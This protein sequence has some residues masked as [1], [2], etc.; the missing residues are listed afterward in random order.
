MDWG[1]VLR[2]AVTALKTLP[3]Q[4]LQD[5]QP[6][7]QRLKQTIISASSSAVER[8]SPFI[9]ISESRNPS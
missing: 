3:E 4:R 6:R 9:V 8:G 7:R 1:C 2:L 5:C